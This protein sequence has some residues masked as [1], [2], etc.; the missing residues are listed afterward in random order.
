[1]DVLASIESVTRRARIMHEKPVSFVVDCF[2]MDCENRT[3]TQ[4][5]AS[6]ELSDKDFDLAVLFLGN[7]GRLL[8]RSYIHKVVWGGKGAV[9]SRTIDTHVS[10]IRSKLGLVYER[11]WELKAVYA[12]GYRL[13]RTQPPALLSPI[14]ARNGWSTEQV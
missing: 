11:G 12:H 14:R 7:L 4:D 8:S 9:A 6:L 10:R 13:E 5:G 1:M 3:I 2:H